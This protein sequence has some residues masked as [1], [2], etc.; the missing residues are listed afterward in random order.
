MSFKNTLLT[1]IGRGPHLPTGAGGD[2]SKSDG[3]T[4]LQ[5]QFK[6]NIFCLQHGGDHDREA[7]VGSTFPFHH[8]TLGPV[9]Y[10]L[11]QY[12]ATYQFTLTPGRLSQQTWKQSLGGLITAPHLPGSLGCDR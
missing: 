12:P 10:L 2:G 11:T 6:V 7:L 8:K 4:Q 1:N 5:A 9:R 3:E